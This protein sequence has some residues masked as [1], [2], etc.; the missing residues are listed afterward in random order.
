[1]HFNGIQ[2]S[3]FEWASHARECIRTFHRVIKGSTSCELYLANKID[4]ASFD[5]I[6]G[7]PVCRIANGFLF[8]RDETRISELV[9]PARRHNAV[10]V[11]SIGFQ[12]W[13]RLI[14]HGFQNTRCPVY[15]HAIAEIPRN[16]RTSFT[17]LANDKTY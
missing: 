13:S 1:M 9:R 8:N 3:G 6:R 11:Q 15:T 10:R 2:Q 12:E 16:L 17:S 5:L 4:P 14:E 7:L